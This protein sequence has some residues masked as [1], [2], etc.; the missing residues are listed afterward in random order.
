M[1]G[2]T[3]GQLVLAI[4]RSATLRTVKT[5]S[6]KVQLLVRTV[7]RPVESHSGARETIIAGPYHNDTTFR[8]RQDGE[9]DHPTIGS[10]D[11]RK[12]PQR[13]SGRS[14]GRK[15]NL[16]IFEVRKKPSGT[17]FSVL[18]SDGGALQTSRGPGKLSPHSP[19]STGLTV[20]RN[21]RR[22]F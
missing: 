11:H 5:Q 3:D 18:L 4:P 16:C 1:D 10:G 6:H 19:L 12:L 21:R 2:R 8:M 9:A 20:N 17:P 22:Y 14:P 15:W 13:D 7:N